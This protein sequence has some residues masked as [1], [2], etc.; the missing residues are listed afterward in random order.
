LHLLRKRTE[1]TPDR[2]H[3]EQSAQRGVEGPA[4]VLVLALLLLVI[5]KKF[6]LTQFF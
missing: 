5:A 3:P 4:V 6:I 1:A 2:R